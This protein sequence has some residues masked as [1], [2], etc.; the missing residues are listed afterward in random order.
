MP[1]KTRSHLF[2]I[3]HIPVRDI[4]RDPNSISNHFLYFV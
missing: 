4:L 2:V 1:Q 3:Q